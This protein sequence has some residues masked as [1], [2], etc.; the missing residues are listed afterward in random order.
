MSK[1]LTNKKKNLIQ[2]GGFLPLLALLIPLLVKA[3]TIA[4]P[5]IT[6]GALAG[7]AGTAVSA[8]IGKIIGKTN[9]EFT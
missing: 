2:K 9:N 4:G 3:A 5:L 1:S 6:K 8:V 7:A